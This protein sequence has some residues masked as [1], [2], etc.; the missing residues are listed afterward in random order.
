MLT[1][2]QAAEPQKQSDVQ[3]LQPMP[4]QPTSQQLIRSLAARYG[5][6]PG[7][8]AQNRRCKQ[9][10]AEQPPHVDEH[11]GRAFQAGHDTQQQQLDVGQ[12]DVQAAQG[13]GDCHQDEDTVQS[14]L[15]NLQ[16]AAARSGPGSIS[17]HRRFIASAATLVTAC[18][19]QLQHMSSSQ[20]ELQ[21]SITTLLEHTPAK[22]VPSSDWVPNSGNLE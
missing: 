4:V 6:L 3:L 8:I 22:V 20:Q 10:A 16:H 17:D 21:A 18:L 7:I 2:N 1:E 14:A 13:G 15:A 9:V 19:E 11:I 5:Q 12:H